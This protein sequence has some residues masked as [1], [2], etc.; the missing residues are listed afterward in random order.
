M[1]CVSIRNDNLRLLIA[2]K[3][4]LEFCFR[5][6]DADMV[7]YNRNTRLETFLPP[8]DRTDIHLLATRDGNGFN[9][10]CLFFRVSPISVEMLGANAM[11]NYMP[12]RKDFDFA[13]QGMLSNIVRDFPRYNYSTAIV[14]T[15]EK[16]ISV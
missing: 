4:F 7:V 15:A 13:E 1:D 6:H 8:K 10:G 5:L 2:D 16:L 9:A 14:S 12:G 3:K 11:Y